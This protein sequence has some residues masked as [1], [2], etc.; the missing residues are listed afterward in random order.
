[1]LFKLG[2]KLIKGLPRIVVVGA[3]AGIAWSAL[4]VDHRLP[5]GPALPGSRLG[6]VDSQGGALNL[7]HDDGG[8][9]DPVLLVHSVNAAASSFEMRPLYTRLQ[10]E[11]PVWSIDLP[12]FGGSERGDRS[13]TPV[14][15]TSAIVSSLERIGPAH[16]VALSLG[17]EFAARAAVDRPD[18]IK[19]LT[20]VSPTGFDAPRDRG[21]G[22]GTALRFPVWAQAIYDGIVTR[23]SIRYFLAKYFSGPADESMVEY[24]HSTAHQPGA[25]HAPLAFLAGDLFT[26]D[27]V[28]GLYAQVTVPTLVLY[29]RDPFTRF[30]R[31][32]EFLADHPRWSA[33]RIADTNG[34]PHWDRPAETFDALNEHWASLE[35]DLTTA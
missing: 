35:Q 8:D 31:L 28:E 5:L 34:L 18:L 4:G 22:L 21:S 30:V 29:D 12:G 1:M 9:G 19:S 32:P 25:R 3:G 17:S 23:R 27:A 14:L 13:Y 24:A 6:G 16:V 10:D 2:W 20:L 33:T 15:M 26:A 11:R 7:Y